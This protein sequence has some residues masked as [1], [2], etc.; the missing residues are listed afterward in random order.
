MGIMAKERQPR[1]ATTVEAVEAHV[2]DLWNSFQR[3]YQICEK[4]VESLLK[5]QQ[6][7]VE[8]VGDA[9]K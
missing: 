4:L 8:A 7:V 3:Q 9:T 2:H 6:K 5:R 1:G